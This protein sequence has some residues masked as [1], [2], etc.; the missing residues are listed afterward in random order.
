M[1]RLGQAFVFIVIFIA[2]ALFARSVTAQ[3]SMETEPFASKPLCLPDVYLTDP[4]DCL[5]LGPAQKMTELA[6]KGVT[7]PLR[8][9]PAVT[10]D[11]ALAVSPVNIARINIDKTEQA[12]LYATFEDATQGANPTRF[13][14]PGVLRYVSYID[15]QYYN[16]NPYIRLHSGEWMRASPIAYSDFQ[17]LLFIETPKNSFGWIVDAAEVHVAPGYA[18]ATTG[19]P[20]YR[21]DVVQIYDVQPANNTDWYMIGLDQ[22]VERRYIRQV[23]IDATPPEGVTGDRWIDINLYDQTLTVYENRQLVFATLIVSGG[24]PFYTRPGLFQVYEKHETETMSGSFEADRSDYY[25]LEN[26]PWTMYFDK[27]RAL[28]GAYWR[29]WFGYAGTHGCVN[30]SIGDSAWLFKWANVGEWVHVWDPS[31]ET[32]TDPNFYGEGGA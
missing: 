32:P 2:A 23:R 28:H 3:S 24:E 16:D 26:V 7:V 5:L 20:L 14:A 11:K 19:R 22:W 25:Y 4:V 27:A 21:E 9:L 12:A 10:P 29:A 15:V 6:R 17:G 13:I 18:S 1:K 8:P 30:L 31:G